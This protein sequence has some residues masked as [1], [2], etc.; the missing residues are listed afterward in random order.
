MKY[1]EALPTP[2]DFS[3][4]FDIA[5]TWLVKEMRL[6]WL[7]DGKCTKG[8]ANDTL[9]ALRQTRH[10]VGACHGCGLSVRELTAVVEGWG[11]AWENS[12]KTTEHEP[13]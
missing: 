1:T 2:D 7:P 9:A 12:K 10:L 8:T 13:R 4:A 5:E 3:R 11:R 6:R